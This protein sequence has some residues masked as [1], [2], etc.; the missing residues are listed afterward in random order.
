MATTLARTAGV[1]R[2]VAASG[3]LQSSRPR[4]TPFALQPLRLKLPSRPAG[5]QLSV[6]LA[7]S[8]E[9]CMHL[10]Y[11][12]FRSTARSSMSSELST[13]SQT[14]PAIPGGAE[15]S[16]AALLIPFG[17]AMPRARQTPCALL[18]DRQTNDPRSSLLHRRFPGLVRAAVASCS[19]TL[20]T[21]PAAPTALQAMPCQIPGCRPR[22]GGAGQGV[23]L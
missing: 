5:A 2:P 6:K 10:S 11:C 20:P 7:Q 8:A 22:G 1:V 16:F 15:M 12:C 14:R 19:K 17:A 21:R 23:G 13:S 4:A 9:K 3:R 18:A